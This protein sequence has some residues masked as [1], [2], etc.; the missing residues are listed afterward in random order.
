MYSSLLRKRVLDWLSDNVPPPRI[1]HILGVEQIA[2]QWARLYGINAEKAAWAGL[3]HDLAKY[4][5]HDL[6]LEMARAEGL[7]L[8]PILET[9]PHLI[10]ADI[11]A[12]VAREQFGIVDGEILDAI[13]NHTLG[14]PGMS[15]LSCIIYLADALEPNR[16]QSDRLAKLRHL[17]EQH[18]YR[19]VVATSNDSLQYLIAKDCPIHPRTV[20][21]RNWFLHQVAQ[22]PLPVFEETIAC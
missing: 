9:N 14:R 3:L 5:S 12:I 15:S 6:L 11:G 4:F 20:Q 18:L 8:D 10:H 22:S 17:V 21:T 19:A 1:R 13:R 16:G 7:R 2:S